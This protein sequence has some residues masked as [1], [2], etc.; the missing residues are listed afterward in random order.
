MSSIVNNTKTSRVMKNSQA[1]DFDIHEKHIIQF[2]DGAIDKY[3]STH[4]NQVPKIL[5]MNKEN[6]D[7]L[8]S[9]LPKLYGHEE[10][11]TLRGSTIVVD[12]TLDMNDV[13]AE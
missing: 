8:T 2:A 12:N 10:A 13:V 6:A 7:K 9:M 3:Q 4:D 1:N 11:K 5:R